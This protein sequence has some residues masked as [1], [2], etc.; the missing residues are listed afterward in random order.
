MSKQF[1]ALAAA[2]LT[3]FGWLTTTAGAASPYGCF[4]VNISELNIRDRPYSSAKVIG[5]AK[6]GDVLEKRKRWC[7][8]RGYWCAIRTAGG[9]EGYADKS[10]MDKIVCP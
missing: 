9:L 2:T 6:Q 10:Y 1:L 3:A 7:T 5:I 4:R 8:L